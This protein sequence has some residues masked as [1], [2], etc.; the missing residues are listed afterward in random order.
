MNNY[1]T[2]Y[3][4]DQATLNGSMTVSI[5]SLNSTTYNLTVSGMDVTHEDDTGISIEFKGA[6][7]FI[8]TKSGGSVSEKTQIDSSTGAITITSGGKVQTVDMCS[9][10]RTQNSG[11]F[12]LGMAGDTMQFEPAGISGAMVLSVINPLVGSV[13]DS[14]HPQSGKFL[15]K[16]PDNSSVTINISTGGAVTLAVDTNGDGTIDGTISTTFDELD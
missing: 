12:N 1:I 15:I 10:N 13:S 14:V 4:G 11:V 3:S 7:K 6:L 5:D 2:T 16:A 8:R 9:I